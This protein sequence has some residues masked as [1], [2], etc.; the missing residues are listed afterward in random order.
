[1]AQNNLYPWSI[2]CLDVLPSRFVR[3]YRKRNDAIE[4]ARILAIHTGNHYEVCYELNKGA[5]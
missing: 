5:N 2:Y 1:M 4:Y 3:A